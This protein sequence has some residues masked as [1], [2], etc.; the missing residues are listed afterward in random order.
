LARQNYHVV[1]IGRSI[2]RLENV[3]NEIENTHG[4]ASCYS[5]DISNAEDVK[6]CIDAVVKVFC[7]IDVLFNN[8]GIVKLGTTNIHSNEINE[9][10]QINFLGAIYVANAVA[11]FMKQQRSG[12]IINIS[13]MAGKRALPV[14]GIYSAS[15]YGLVGYA[16]ALFKELLSY[17][18]KVTTIC[19]GT[20]ATDMT[21]NVYL[22]D[23]LMIQTSD[24]VDTVRFLLSL[25]NT[26]A[27]QEILIQCTEFAS[28]EIE[29]V[30]EKFFSDIECNL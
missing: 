18:I 21:K 1:L 13:S 6:K 27:I 30:T 4:F 2:A 12:Y 3:K 20:V 14:T 17:G 28:K 8:A 11:T 26:A 25:G 10:I 9:I 24:I 16:E 19:P 22:S 29:A 15:K 5:L 7:R 23:K